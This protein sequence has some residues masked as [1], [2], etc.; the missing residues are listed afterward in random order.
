MPRIARFVRKDMP[1]VYHVISR[2]ALQGLPIQGRDNDYLLSL[3]TK[4]KGSNIGTSMIRMSRGKAEVS[5][6][7]QAF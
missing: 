7:P 3:I 2:T 6:P 5:L 1:T 4:L